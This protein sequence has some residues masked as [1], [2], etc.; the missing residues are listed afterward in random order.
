M[1]KE[2]FISIFSIFLNFGFIF[3]LSNDDCRL[4][5]TSE[6]PTKVTGQVA[7]YYGNRW[8]PLCGALW[9]KNDAQVTCRATGYRNGA[10]NFTTVPNSTYD[11][12][13]DY[14]RYSGFHCVGNEEKLQDCRHEIDP[15][16]INETSQCNGF[17][18]AICIANKVNYGLISG[19]IGGCLLTILLGIGC[20]HGQKFL[21]KRMGSDI[22][23]ET[24][25]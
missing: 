6:T 11:S 23:T 15:I 19:I 14:F 5:V 8:Y 1:K 20:Y 18:V 17:A 3:S 4:I 16:F 2:H 24:L 25:L 13:L 21:R 7:I 12:D 10:H 22:M 9:D